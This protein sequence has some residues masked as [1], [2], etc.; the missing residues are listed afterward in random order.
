M[1]KLRPE[2]CI[3][4]ETYCTDRSRSVIIEL[5]PFFCRVSVKGTRESHNVDWDAILDLGRKMDARSR[6]QERRRA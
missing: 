2:R 1:L 4:R 3:K 6:E 5:F